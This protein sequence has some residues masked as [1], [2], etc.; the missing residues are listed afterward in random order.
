MAEKGRV[1]GEY[2]HDGDLDLFVRGRPYAC[3]VIGAERK[4]HVNGYV[5]ETGQQVCQRSVLR[6]WGKRTGGK[7]RVTGNVLAMGS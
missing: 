7:S 6:V 4:N 1:I 2:S 5:F 3:G